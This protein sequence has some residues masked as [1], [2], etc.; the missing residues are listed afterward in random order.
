MKREV[1]LAEIS[2]GRL[3]G[4]NDMVRADCGDCEG[5]SA[6][7]HDM[8]VSIVL[9]PLDCHRL[10]KFTGVSVDGL[11]QDKLELH[12]VD[13]MILPNLS[14]SGKGQACGFLDDEGRCSVHPAR[15]DICRM[16]PLGRIYEE[17]GFR[18]FLQVHECRKENR[19][20]VKV[21]KWLDEPETAKNQAFIQKWHDLLGRIR[22]ELDESGDEEARKSWNMYILQTFYLTPYRKDFYEEFETRY[23]EVLCRL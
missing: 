10:S 4:L 13:G 14:M 2:D 6:C 16:F 1:D 18:Y 15:P 9:T 11:L 7:C 19:S 12:V 8:G 17:N 5:C 23:R 3:Y 21:K 22:G 20:K